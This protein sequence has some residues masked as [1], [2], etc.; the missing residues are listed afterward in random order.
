MFTFADLLSDTI[1]VQVRTAC[2][3]TRPCSIPACTRV[4]SGGCSW[5]GTPAAAG[6]EALHDGADARLA[7]DARFVFAVGAGSVLPM[8]AEV[9]PPV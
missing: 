4:G 1:D 6:A 3:S 8:G 5:R 9:L 7:R 2:Y